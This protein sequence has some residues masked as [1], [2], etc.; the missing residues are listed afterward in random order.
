[1][2]CPPGGRCGLATDTVTARRATLGGCSKRGWGVYLAP[3][4]DTTWPY[5]GSFTWPWTAPRRLWR[6]CRPGTSA[7]WRPCSQAIQRVEAER[8]AVCRPGGT[9]GY[10]F[11][12]QHEH[13]WPFLSTPHD[14]TTRKA[15]RNVRFQARQR[16]DRS[17]SAAY[18]TA[19]G[20]AVRTP[21]PPRPQTNAGPLS[22]RRRQGRNAFVRALAAGAGSAAVV[23]AL[24]IPAA[25]S[26]NP[27]PW[28]GAQVGLT[29][30]VYQPKT[31]LSIPMSSFKLLPCQAVKTSQ[32]SPRSV[33]PIPPFRTMAR[34]RVFRW[35]KVTRSFVPTR[36]LPN[37]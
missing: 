5:A 13:D 23:A 1:M 10:R 6:G 12:G 34:S 2:E 14:I 16:F 25:A 37:R 32:F 29:Y 8:R 28:D 15:D 31:L 11:S 17:T 24:A 30:P 35:P 22:P 33:R 4:G 21:P 7:G 36:V 18:K 19:A 3:S 9:A 20:K 26:G 27:N